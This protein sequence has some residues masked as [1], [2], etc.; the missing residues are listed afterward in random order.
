MQTTP[1]RTPSMQE[2]PPEVG[3]AAATRLLQSEYGIDAEVSDLRSERDR[4]F[5]AH[6]ADGRRLVVKV[7]NTGDDPQQ[8]A[9]ENAAMQHVEQVD[10][11]LPIPRVL[12][13]LDGRS[14]V[15]VEAADGRTHLVRVMTVMPGEVADLMA[16]PEWF[17]AEF[18]SVSARL[19]RALQGF[20]H[21]AAYRRLDW[22]PRIVTT[23]RPY[24]D[25]L[26]DDT[27][28]VPMHRL[29][30]R[31]E[32]LDA[33]AR[34]LPGFVLHGDV[35]LSNVLLRDGGITG[36]IDFGDMHHTARIAELAISLTSLL[37]ESDDLW[38]D[39]GRFLDG[40]QRVLPL[41]PAEVE[42][43]GELVLARS[44]ASVLI[45]AWRAPL[46]P[47]NEE[48]LTSLVAGS[49]RILDELTDVPAGDL[50][51][52]FHSLC[53]TK[54]VRSAQAADP[55]LL[56]R[57]QTALGGQL[58]PL[59]YRSPLQVV[60]AAGAWIH[61]ADGRRY[62][63]AYNNVPVVGHAHPAVVQAISRQAAVLN[64]NSRYLHANVVELAERL[65]ASMPDGLDT[66]VFANSGSEANDLAWRMARVVTGRGGAIVADLSYH[67]VS[68]ATAAFSTN[69]YPPEARPPHVAIFEAPRQ[70]TDDGPAAVQRVRAARADLQRAGHDLA[71]LAVDTVFSSAGILTP[72]D[73][74]MRGL[75]DEAQ[76]SG[77]LFLADEVQAGFGR[78]G[79]NLWRFQDFGLTPDFVT[80]GK[81]MGN[82]HPVAALITR[83]EIAE[84]FVEVDEYFSTFGGNP[85]S[86]VAALTVLD[87]IEQ[88][89]LVQRSGQV[90]A[91]LRAGLEALVPNV[92]G[93]GLMVGVELPDAADFAERLREYG[94]LI[95]TTGPG[96]GVLK[97]RPPLIWESAEVEQFLTAFQ[98]ALG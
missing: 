94:V 18:G 36:V 60:R 1:D 78:G 14:A 64:L 31:F 62:L 46:Y 76:A 93:Q 98:K 33:A 42:L 57:R 59:F 58:S 89:G 26:P 81:P 23:L 2:D 96:G 91:E 39:A 41:E 66:C 52:R 45:S 32:G 49:W 24:A 77:G 43:I 92:R 95:G 19:T 34:E 20:G 17:G 30:D 37:R 67:G 3:V 54:R 74:F 38:R 55:T 44:A 71:L 80:L 75:Q 84:A 86:C 47:D 97:I 56:V 65:T 10:P 48:Y 8:I 87:V 12:T 50:A 21:P 5:L 85:V 82:G 25:R 83:R 72:A 51:A 68:E 88:T 61:T 90:G 15:T 40:Y 69:T 6:A 13:S 7:S 22:D 4:N 73:S 11:D 70:V 28:R 79:R 29:L 9:M 16:L 27:R 35:T 53:G 63:D